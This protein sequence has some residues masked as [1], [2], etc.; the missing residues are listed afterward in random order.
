M[1]G[2]GGREAA[3]QKKMEMDR[4]TDRLYPLKNTIYLRE[5]V[6]KKR[7]AKIWMTEHLNKIKQPLTS[8]K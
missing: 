5:H 8:R 4:L 2:A 7:I 6:G 3:S 1:N